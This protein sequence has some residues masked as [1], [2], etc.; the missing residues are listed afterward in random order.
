MLLKDKLHKLM[1]NKEKNEEF[2]GVVLIKRGEEEIFS[3]AYG[4]ANRSFKVKN[5]LDTKFR[6][7]SITKMFTAISILKLIEKGKFD[8]DTE[9]VKYLKLKETKIP[10]EVNVYHLL[11]HTSGI[12]DYFDEMNSDDEDWE[13]LWQNKPI[14]NMRSLSDYFP[15]FAYNKPVFNVGEKFQYNGAGYILLGMVIEKASGM[16]YFNYVRK[17]IFKRLDMKNSDFLSLDKVYDNVAEGYEIV[18]DKDNNTITCMRNIYTTT[19]NAASDGGSTSTANDLMIFIDA[20][21]NYRLLSSEMTKKILSPQV[22]YESADGF[23][24][25]KWRYGFANYLILDNNDN[26]IRGGHTGEEYGVSCRLYYYPKL[27]IDVVILSNQ[28]LCA[29]SLGWDIHDIILDSKL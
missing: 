8:F 11:T 10:K 19:P 17:N 13:K 7:A 15:M 4:Y 24:G 20:L 16:S 26:V 3:G 29:G 22:I 6:I 12:A 25:Y 23:R 1:I 5:T 18:K 27:N 2:S 14:Y 28:G 9:I 21:K